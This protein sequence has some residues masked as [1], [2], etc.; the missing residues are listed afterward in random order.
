MSL[1][2]IMLMF[3]NYFFKL[4]YTTYPKQIFMLKDEFLQLGLKGVLLTILIAV[5]IIGSLK[6]LFTKVLVSD[7]T[8]IIVIISILISSLIVSLYR[9]KKDTKDNEE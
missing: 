4:D 1:S 3:N 6:L 5:V 8:T 2:W 7:Y 9:K